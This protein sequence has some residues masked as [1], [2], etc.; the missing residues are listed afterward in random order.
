MLEARAAAQ[1]P[2]KCSGTLHGICSCT[3]EQK[4]LVGVA[5]AMILLSSSQNTHERK[6]SRVIDVHEVH[7]LHP[8]KVPKHSACLSGVMVSVQASCRDVDLILVM[9]FTVFACLLSKNGTISSL[10]G[11][12]RIAALKTTTRILARH[13]CTSTV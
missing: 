9:I 6:S 5:H 7:G 10:L 8:C 12:G 11:A 2:G 3:F 13:S 1:S 4:L